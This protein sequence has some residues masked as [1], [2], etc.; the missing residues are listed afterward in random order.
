M[1]RNFQTEIQKCD[2]RDFMWEFFYKISD[3]K[4]LEPHEEQG[5][6]WKCIEK[7]TQKV[8]GM[9]V[10]DTLSTTFINRIA[11]DESYRRCGIAIE[12]LEF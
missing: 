11:V 4:N 12:L 7:D 2:D 10:V 8:I 5:T 9:A 6:G 3:V 1:T